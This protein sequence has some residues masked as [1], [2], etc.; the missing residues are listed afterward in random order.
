MWRLRVLAA[1]ALIEGIAL[2]GYALFDIYGAI[3]IGTTGPEEVSNPPALLL[4]ILMFALFGAGLIAV[5][6]AW[7]RRLRWARAP[8]LVAQFIAIIVGWPLAQSEGGVERTAG[9]V[10]AALAIVGIIIAFTPSI[11]R[12]LEADS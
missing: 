7:M 4:Q 8:F 5:S 6:Y 10:L 11:T 3:T 12:A 1:I 9:I 2:V